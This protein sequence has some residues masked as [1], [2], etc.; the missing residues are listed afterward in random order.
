MNKPYIPL[1]VPRTVAVSRQNDTFRYLMSRLYTDIQN[2]FKIQY[3]EFRYIRGCNGA[4][5]KNRTE[6]LECLNTLI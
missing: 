4:S 6:L 2:S 1:I 3:S 5:K